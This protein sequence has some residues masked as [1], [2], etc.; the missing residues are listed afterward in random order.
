LIPATAFVTML[1]TTWPNECQL[2][3]QYFADTI[4]QVHQSINRLGI[5]YL[6]IYVN[7]RIVSLLL[8]TGGTVPISENERLR[9]LDVLWNKL[10]KVTIVDK[11][12]F[13]DWH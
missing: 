9:N 6:D 12:L 4:C 8:C 10:T 1:T 3:R 5:G 2:N 11:N 7:V 13:P